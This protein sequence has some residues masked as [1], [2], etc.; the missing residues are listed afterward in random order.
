MDTPVSQSFDYEAKFNWD[1][2]T[3][4]N[5]VVSS[6]SDANTANCNTDSSLAKNI[7]SSAKFTNTGTKT[8]DA[9]GVAIE[10][11]LMNAGINA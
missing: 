8:L 5:T 10:G 1:A 6:V 2:S 3:T 4:T 9:I 11:L 7:P